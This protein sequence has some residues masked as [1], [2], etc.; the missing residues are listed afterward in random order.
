MTLNRWLFLAFVESFGTICVERGI[1]FFAHRHLGFSDGAN[2]W[3]SFAFGA[4][5][6]CGA[7]SCHRMCAWRSERWVLLAALA[8]SL[9]GNAGLALFGRDA[10]WLFVLNALLGF[11]NGVKWP[12]IESQ[13]AAGRD[14][15]G[16]ARAIGLFN[17]AWASAVP[18]A[19]VFCGP[20][21]GAW[22]AGL[23]AAPAVINLAA[24][25]LAWRAPRSPA[26]LP[27]SHPS[28]P[29]PERCVQLR[30]LL[31][32]S[33]WLLLLTY[34]TLWII[35]ALIPSILS[36]LRVPDDRAP[37]LS[38]LLD[39]ARFAAF[40]VLWFW[41]GWVG[42]AWCVWAS[43][44]ALPITFVLIVGVPSLPVVIVGGI[45]FG[46]AAGVVYYAA[47]YY[48][49]VVHNAAVDAGG[50]HEALI[51]SGFALGPLLGLAAM[52]IGPHVGG[53]LAGTLVGVGP[54]IVVC[55]ALCAARLLGLRKLNPPIG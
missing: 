9:C 3:L 16:Q 49:M 44:V 2:L 12:V 51:G 21:I 8:V 10:P 34:S 41:R 45:L 54:L 42:Q 33:R 24:L 38:G 40:A 5:Y 14:E 30:G 39:A 11:V 26:H 50:G 19:L 27:D 47:I 6:V 46:L 36:T 25:A 13:I 37:A 28:R 15:A 43:A 55:V 35:S 48:A 22:P 31:A 29:S 1:F 7:V 17:F 4:A 18:P 52:A 23:F 32:A 20:I 53:R